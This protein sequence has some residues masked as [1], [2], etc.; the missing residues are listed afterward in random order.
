MDVTSGNAIQKTC[1]CETNDFQRA[2]IKMD[3]SAFQ[4]LSEIMLHPWKNKME[5]YVG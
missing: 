5:I 2:T 3:V 4:E 1:I